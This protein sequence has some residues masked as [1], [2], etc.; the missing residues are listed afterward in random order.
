MDLV[1]GVKRVI[2]LMEH[3]AKKKDG[4]EHLKILPKCTL[5]LTGVGVVDRIITDLGVIDVTEQGLKVVELAPGRDVRAGAVQDRRHSCSSRPAVSAAHSADVLA[6]SGGCRLPEDALACAHLTGGD[7]V[8][9][10]S[11]AVATAAQ[12]HHRRRRAGRVRAGHVRG[13]PRQQVAVDMRACGRR[14]PGW[15]SLDGRVPEPWDAFSG[16]YRCPRRLCAHPRQLRASPG[17]CAAPARARSRAGATAPTPKQAMLQWDALAFEEAAAQAGLV[18]TALR[19]FAQWDASAAGP[20]HCRAAAVHDHSHRRR[21]RRC[22]CP[23][24][25]EQQRPLEGVRVLDLTRILAGPVGGRALAA[26]GADVMLVNSP[27]PAQHRR[28]RRHQPR[29]ALGATGPAHATQGARRDGR[30][31]GRC[32]R[33]RPGLSARRLAGAG[34][35]PADA[36]RARG[37]ASCACRSP[38]TARKGRGRRGAA[39]TPWCRPRR[40][41]TSPKAR[42]PASRQAAAAADA[43]PRP[44]DRLPH[45]FRRRR[46]AVPPA[47]RGR[48]LARAGVAGADGPLAARARPRGRRACAPRRRDLEPYLETSASGFGALRGAAPQRAARAARRPRWVRPSVPPGILAAALVIFRQDRGKGADRR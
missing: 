11:F 43:D 40:A 37:R 20:G 15:F 6:A 17:R 19:S 8:C 9:P 18:A 10:S 16:L 38:P 27:A 22:R 1:A 24:C 3:V 46:R 42:R 33:V 36:G 29:Q 39:S 28:H 31:A 34:L 7:P 23:G 26:Y 25:T 2:V 32:A 41:S 30:A 44:G 14:M 47:A 45:R 21:R 4:T 13:V 5:P 48:Q 12:C 35:R